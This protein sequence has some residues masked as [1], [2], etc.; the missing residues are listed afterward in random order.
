MPMRAKQSNEAGTWGN[1][2]LKRQSNAQFLERFVIKKFHVAEGQATEHSLCFA[3]D[4]DW[5][6][7]KSYFIEQWRRDLKNAGHPVMHF[8]AW[9]NDLADDP[10]IGFMSSLSEQIRPWLDKLPVG[11]K[12]T[13]EAKK[14]W[15]K[16]VSNAGKLVL[17]IGKV[18][19][20][21]A[22]KRITGVDVDDLLSAA[23]SPDKTLSEENTESLT[24]ELVSGSTAAVGK[25][26]EDVM[27]AHEEKKAA[28]E[29]FRTSLEQLISLLAERAAAQLPMFV[30]VD[31]LDRCKPD[32]AIRLLEGIKHFFQVRGVCFVVATNLSQLAESTKAVYG[33]GF[34]SVRYLKR[35]FAFEYMLPRPDHLAFAEGLLQS[36][37]FQGG[38]GHSALG[39]QNGSVARDFA[40]LSEAFNLDLRSQGQVLLYAEAAGAS[41]PDDEPI[42]C[43]PMFFLAAVLHRD[44]KV[45]E[46]IRGGW[47]RGAVAA[48]ELLRSTGFVDR[49]ARP[50]RDDESAVSCSAILKTYVRI[51]EKPFGEFIRLRRRMNE[52]VVYPGTLLDEVVHHSSR[53]QSTG[54]QWPGWKYP[55]L[56]VAAGQLI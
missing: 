27:K 37:I 24:S 9:A 11:E 16:I 53:K 22:A 44:R 46:Q 10:L 13:M 29:S 40:I 35:F 36:S 14:S 45:F 6:A 51:G 43:F 25:W 30:M 50:A 12:A 23:S 34:D 17:P 38:R 56:L 5:G 26:F 21:S 55:R 48:D 33:S 54:E 7:G 41:V 1:D 39:G 8:D 15:K 3:V 28:V 49:V 47:E 42:Y 19:A 18:I 31:E 32:Y 4:G 2:L 52:H 20:A